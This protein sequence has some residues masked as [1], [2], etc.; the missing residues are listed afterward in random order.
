MPG[1]LLQWVVYQTYKD[2]PCSLSLYFQPPKWNHL[3]YLKVHFSDLRLLAQ[4]PRANFVLLRYLFG[5]LHNIEQHSSSNQMTAYNL[6][7]CI[8]PS[9]LCPPNSCS[10]ELEDNVIRKVM[11]AL[12]FVPWRGEG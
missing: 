6:S 2:V 7:V 8:A 11:R 5:V 3:P 12:I 10:L 1:T 9:I 4:L